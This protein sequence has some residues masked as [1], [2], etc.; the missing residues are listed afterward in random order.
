MINTVTRLT[1][2]F[3]VDPHAAEAAPAED[4]Y[5]GVRSQKSEVRNERMV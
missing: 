4:E 5:L 1:Q 3:M 2:Y